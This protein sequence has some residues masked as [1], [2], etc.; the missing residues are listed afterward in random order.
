MGKYTTTKKARRG[1]TMAISSGADR[2][3]FPGQSQKR[4]MLGN[5]FG[6]GPRDI[7]HSITGGRVADTPTGGKKNRSDD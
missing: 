1:Q 4:A 5:E 3:A 6:G 2:D 7:S